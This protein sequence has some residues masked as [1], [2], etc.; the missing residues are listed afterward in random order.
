M[1]ILNEMFGDGDS[2]QLP[3]PE[4][5]LLAE[6]EYESNAEEIL[7][8]YKVYQKRYVFMSLIWKMLLVLLAVTSSVMMIMTS[9]DPIIP[10]MC[11]MI[12]IA[13]GIWFINTPISNRKK[14]MRGLDIMEE[15][16]YK[17][18]FYTDKIKISTCM[19]DI[20]ETENPDG[21]ASEQPKQDE[22]TEQTE[23]DMALDGEKEEIPAT[24][25]HLDSPIVDLIDKEDMFIL[26]VKKS[27]V[28]IIP[29]TAFDDDKCEKIRE[30]L[31]VIMGI[32]YKA[33]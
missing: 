11:L 33:Y 30:K 24:V 29:K 31:S 18:E 6:G 20:A 25:I 3:A 15:T 27:Y 10:A 1:G 32:R 9:E 4:G 28:F 21:N 19:E 5:E 14:L 13:V 16:R 26:V 12:S 22:Q 17:A 23:A 8:G 2:G 7:K